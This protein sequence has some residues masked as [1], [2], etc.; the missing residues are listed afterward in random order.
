MRLILIFLSITLT[1]FSYDLDP[2]I[3]FDN[4]VDVRTGDWIQKKDQAIYRSTEGH[5][6][7]APHTRLILRGPDYSICEGYEKTGLPITYKQFKNS[8]Y[9]IQ[10]PSESTNSAMG[11]IGAHTF[12]GNQT[13]DRTDKF[14]LLI[15][16][17]E[18]TRRVYKKFLSKNSDLHFLLQKELFTDGSVT[19]YSY[20]ED[21]S[22]YTINNKQVVIPDSHPLVVGI[23]NE[24]KGNR[25]KYYSNHTSI[26]HPDGSKSQYG[27]DERNRL[28]SLR[29]WTAD[30]KLIEK[31]FY[32]FSENGCL[33]EL[34]NH[35]YIYDEKGN[36]CEEW[37]NGHHFIRTFDE[38]NQIIDLIDEC[39]NIRITTSYQYSKLGELTRVTIDNGNFQ[40]V[41]E[42]TGGEKT[43]SAVYESV[44]G[45]LLKI[46]RYTYNEQIEKTIYNPDGTLCLANY[47]NPS[48]IHRPWIE[49]YSTGTFRKGNIEFEKDYFGRVV[50]H[51]IFDADENLASEQTWTYDAH[52]LLKHIDEEGLKTTFIYNQKGHK[53][54]KLIH[55]KKG[56]ISTLYTYDE[57]ERVIS[58]TTG[59]IITTYAYD[60]LGALT[61][62]QEK[63]L[64]GTVLTHNASPPPKQVLQITLPADLEKI[65]VEKDIFGNI[66]LIRSEDKS[67][68]Y[69]I[70][71]N[72]R[73][74]PIFIIDHVH[75]LKSSRFYD[76][77]GNLTEETLLN[78]LT[79]KNTRDLYGRRFESVL[80]DNS[81]VYYKWGAK[82]PS[83]IRR[84]SHLGRLDYSHQFVSYNLKGFPVQQRLMGGFGEML[85]ETIDSKVTSVQSRFF[86]QNIDQLEEITIKAAKNPSF[87]KLDALGNII[88]FFD[89]K[90]DRPE[91]VDFEKYKDLCFYKLDALG[92]IIEIIQP[93][94]TITFTY[95][96]WNR[97]M[98]KKV[99]EKHPSNR[100]DPIDLAFVYDDTQEIGAYSKY[101]DKLI[102]LRIFS[103]SIDSNLGKQAIA[104]E[105]GNLLYLPIFDL[106]NNLASL[107]SCNR[108]E[109]MESYQFSSSGACE[110][111]DIYGNLLKKSKALNPWTFKGYRLDIE[112]GLLYVNGSYFD[113]TQEKFLR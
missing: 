85:F 74:Q 69:E 33:L 60:D 108:G 11:K 52:N 98:T 91:K 71:Y 63:T 4:H 48:Q 102:E 37:K 97:R 12:L 22:L 73:N 29:K 84:I 80:P 87:Y 1:V 36:P 92:R 53:T 65:H 20:K 110:I 100:Y 82:F 45:E 78:G 76:D 72:K 103:E 38:K 28:S 94:R 44:G 27:F 42:I 30:G 54:E 46:T 70:S 56:P 43:P 32:L 3:L 50:A 113:P 105:F 66:T 57:K 18:R 19:T 68:H 6:Q 31:N 13:L 95:D 79:L 61:E 104:Y 51:R 2:L 24:Y 35:I 5:W 101:N 14:T 62:T 15:E 106:R 86:T 47:I 83:E 17:P 49:N 109:L 16:T 21:G 9:K 75:G 99:I 59:E 93:E 40:R 34:N 81:K 88:D 89:S 25:F 41:I 23:V 111:L 64:A 112:T 8:K 39:E 10:I 90:I 55:T 77:L 26:E 7:I 67:I 96:P 107:I 58:S